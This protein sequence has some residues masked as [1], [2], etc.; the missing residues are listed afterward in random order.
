MGSAY[1]EGGRPWKNAILHERGYEGF[2]MRVHLMAGDVMD[3]H[4]AH[5]LA[6]FDQT[7]APELPADLAQAWSALAHRIGG[8]FRMG[9]EDVRRPMDQ[10]PRLV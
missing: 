7:V 8:T 1:R 5:L 3:G 10:P 6:A 9:V 4:F 2:P